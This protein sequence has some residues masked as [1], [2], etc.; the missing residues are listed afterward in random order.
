MLEPSPTLV[1][2]V[3]DDPHVRH[4][5]EQALGLAGFDVVV[6]ASAAEALANLDAS[7]AGVVVSDIRMPQMDG[8]AFFRRLREIDED[9]PLLFIT[10]HAD[11][12]EAVEAM[13]EGAYDFIAKPFAVDR[14]VAS[15]RRAL[16]KRSLVL[17]NRQLR[18]LANE[19]AS[20][21]HFIGESAAITALR[22]TIRQIA[23]AAVDVLVEGETGVGKELF[24]RSLHAMGSGRGRPFVALS[25]GAIPDSLMDVELFGHE[26]GVFSASPRRRAGR[27]EMAERGTL[28]LDDIEQAS[29]T[30]QN[31]L[32]R[33]IDEREVLPIGATEARHV[34]FRAIAA[35]R[36]DLAQLVSEGAFRRDL[37]HRLNVVRLRI[38]PL[39]ERRG[40]IPILFAHF[41]SQSA[42]HF[43]RPA[44]DISDSVRRHLIDHD[45]PGN[46][47]ELHHFC[48]RVVL[49]LEAVAPAPSASADI[50]LPDRVE[51]F[52]ESLIKE[53]LAA[54]RG[55]I[56][57]TMQR[58]R[59]PRKTLYDKLRR[60][61]INIDAFRAPAPD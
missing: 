20:A 57:A 2:F 38:P 51:R 59:I 27:I 55:D 18:R 33:V 26:A 31:K 19:A 22:A 44:P 30:L 60:H 56:R 29:P 54:T 13:Q 5:T 21:D 46:V 6:F 4:A 23:D 43:R 39:R 17:D 41:L 10:G 50:S 36:T 35:S 15:V 45:W 11:V 3:D 1:A 24:A 7:F 14:L 40:D 16:E 52:E 49:G 61:R 37:F 53:T 34:Q 28:L 47:R 8:R 9:I 48:E 32:A 42:Q 12:A 58:L 25:C